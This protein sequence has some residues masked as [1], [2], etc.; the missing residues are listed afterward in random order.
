MENIKKIL[1]E[2]GVNIKRESGKEIVI[3]C[4]VTNC[5]QDSGP[6]EGHFYINSDNGTFHCKKCNVEG[7]KHALFKLLNIETTSKK[8][9]TYDP[10]D[11]QHLE[12]KLTVQHLEYLTKRRGLTIETIK[13][14]HIGF[15]HFYGYPCLSIPYFNKDNIFTEMY[16]LRSVKENNSPGSKYLI[17]PKGSQTMLYGLEYLDDT[18]DNILI[19]EGEFDSILASQEGYNSVSIGAGA[20]TFKEMWLKYL[21]PYQTINICFDNDEVGKKEAE[22]LAK[23]LILNF[24]TKQISIIEIPK[25]DNVKDITD[26]YLK[27]GNLSGLLDYPKIFQ[28]PIEKQGEMTLDQLINVLDL[29]IKE[30]NVNKVLTFLCFLNMYTEESQFNIMFNAP[31]STGKSFIPLEIAKLF[32]KEDV[33]EWSKTSPT[34]IFHFDGNYDETSNTNIVDLSK[35]TIIFMDQPDTGLLENIRS[36]LSHDCK[37]ITSNITDRDIKKGMK[38]KTVKIIGFPSVI[39]C[40]ANSW[41]DEQEQTRVILLSPET[42]QVKLLQSVESKITKMADKSL[43]DSLILSNTDRKMLMDRILLIKYSNVNDI[44]IKN[45]SLVERLFLENKKGL[46][47]RDQRDISK[48]MELIKGL[49]LLNYSTRELN[50][51]CILTA[52]DEDIK[53][54]FALWSQISI[55]QLAGISPYILSFLIEIIYDENQLEQ[56]NRIGTEIRLQKDDLIKRFYKLYGRGIDISSMVKKYLKPLVYAG[57]LREVQSE[58]D[59]RTK[60]Y[61]LEETGINIINESVGIPK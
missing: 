49:A 11:Y 32:P 53:S 8:Q 41:I 26:L 58:K 20:S 61:I 7:G 13:K 25:L 28:K 50:T 34:A 27:D 4:P 40:T 44:Q 54:G 55:S 56:H 5:D 52:S 60:D 16:K 23:K 1:N 21:K 57:V 37:I 29:T 59:K 30:D 42:T 33:L 14:R 36:M 18:I 47:P 2:R 45:T 39:F 31:S 19:C 6:K 38:T 3:D 35:K 22:S 9:T 46:I 24:P 43:F 51:E 17:Y 15:S 10:Y 12:T 48:I